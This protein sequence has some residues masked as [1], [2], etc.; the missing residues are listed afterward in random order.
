LKVRKIFVLALIMIAGASLL[1]ISNI[2]YC[3]GTLGRFSSYWELKEFL[4]QKRNG[5]WAWRYGLGGWSSMTESRAQSYGGSDYS[6]TNVQV[7]GVDEGDTVKTDGTYVYVV[8]GQKVVIV[9]A[10][11]PEEAA[12]VSTILVDATVK[13]IFMN[14]ARLA[15][16]SENVTQ[17]GF[18]SIV[19]VYDVSD[20]QN[21]IAGRDEAFDGRYYA[22][23]MMGDYVYVVIRQGVCTTP[24]GEVALPKA[25]MKEATVTTPANRIY[26]SDVA[27]WGYVYTTI[28]AANMQED[29]EPSSYR[30]VMMPQEAKLYVSC[31][32]IY[33]AAYTESTTFIHRIHIDQDEIEIAADGQVPGSVLNQFSMDEHEDHFRIATTSNSWPPNNQLY[34]LNMEL[35]KV[36]SLTDIAPTETIHSVRFMGDI[37]YLVTFKKVDPFF[38]IDLSNPNDPNILGELK[39]TGYSDYLHPFDESR[40]I[41]VGKETADVGSFAWHQGVKISLFDVSDPTEPNELAKYVIGDRGSDSPVLTDHKAFLFDKRRNLVVLPVLETKLNASQSPYLASLWTYGTPVWQGACVFA[42]S[43]EEEE[44]LSLRA[45]ITHFEDGNVSDSSRHITRALYIEDVLYTIS[46]AEIKLNSLLDFRELCVLDLNW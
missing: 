41:G 22:S 5:Y 34:V 18:R 46:T 16:F 43:P 30:T 13:Q 3:A 12:I 28:V 2:E 1:M 14:Q 35:E 25:Y 15:V 44:K 9:K 40:V 33:L 32:N 37:A 27:S 4:G 45:R 29:T 8:S 11:P 39:I 36:G 6:Q 10:Y 19:K 21:P 26:Y 42:V 31:E 38:V 7:E 20:K 17:S 23:R 24:E